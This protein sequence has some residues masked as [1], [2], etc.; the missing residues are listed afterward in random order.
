VTPGLKPCPFC[1]GTATVYGDPVIDSHGIGCRACSACID[2]PGPMQAMV[3]AWNRRH[4][5]P[6]AHL[7]DEQWKDITI[8]AAFKRALEAEREVNRMHAVMAEF[9]S[10]VTSARRTLDAEARAEAAERRVAELE[11]RPM[12]IAEAAKA[13][14]AS[15]AAALPCDHVG[16]CRCIPEPTPKPPT[17]HGIPLAVGQRWV[18]AAGDGPQRDV[19]IRDLFGLKVLTEGA[20][21]NEFRPV[22]W[23]LPEF[24]KMFTRL[25]L[26]E[27]LTPSAASE[28]E[29]PT[30][31]GVRL[32]KGQRWECSNGIDYTVENVTAS[33]GKGATSVEP[34]V[35]VRAADGSG[36]EMTMA[37]RAF[38]KMFPRLLAPASEPAKVEAEPD[39]W[40]REGV[41]AVREYGAP[42]RLKRP[43]GKQFAP[44]CWDAVRLDGTPE[45]ASVR[46]RRPATPEESA[47]L[48][49]EYQANIAVAGL[50]RFAAKRGGGA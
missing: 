29:V 8:E 6:L 44:E 39:G 16:G 13:Y 35:A 43:Q 21:P 20:E 41:W 12:G 50:N 26:P 46:A 33:Y 2:S 15:I 7:S 31:H 40:A 37:L 38:G 3:E 34:M 45:M 28:P 30:V 5:P 17:V 11:S 36:Y 27:E 1:G 9:P 49:A 47:K 24:A 23:D 32:E 22:W 10:T 42:L 19:R 18:H 4:T 14:M 25:R 48:E